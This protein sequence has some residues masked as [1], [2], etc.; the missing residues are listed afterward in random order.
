MNVRCDNMSYIKATY[1]EREGTNVR[2]YNQEHAAF[3]ILLFVDFYDKITMY[4]YYEKG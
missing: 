1:E 3:D 4:R 2:K